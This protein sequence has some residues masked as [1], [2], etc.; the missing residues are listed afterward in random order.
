[1]I[2]GR[3]ATAGGSLAAGKHV[4]NSTF[5][6]YI[7]IYTQTYLHNTQYTAR[8][9]AVGGTTAVVASSAGTSST[10]GSTVAASSSAVAGRVAGAATTGSIVSSRVG[11]LT[12]TTA[13]VGGA[14]AELG[15]TSAE[16][17]AGI[18]AIADAATTIDAGLLGDATTTELVNGVASSSE[19]IT[20]FGGEVADSLA[21][22]AG[23]V[24]EAWLVS[25]GL[26][27]IASEAA[28]AL[29]ALFLL[30]KAGGS[31]SAS[32]VVKSEDKSESI[33]ADTDKTLESEEVIVDALE[34]STEEKA[35]ETLL[36]E[37]ESELTEIVK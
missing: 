14:A 5:L 3:A 8:T 27:A 10:T 15:S 36:E 37:S 34:T 30:L 1:M 25:G 11:S 6:Q 33:I 29:F 17:A 26:A 7:L 2:A 24:G 13:A 16:S 21:V 4:K 31:G 9:A 19:S 12:V 22:A 32:E 20:A 18:S 23:G 28:F 35:T